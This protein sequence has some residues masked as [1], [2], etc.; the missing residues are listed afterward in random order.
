[1]FGLFKRRKKKKEVKQ[2]SI[3]KHEPV[4]KEE[5]V[6]KEEPDVEEVKEE[7]KTPKKR[8]AAMHIT[9]HKDGG[10][11]VKKEGA[12]RALRL[13]GTQKEAIE[14][15]KQVE[16]EKGTGYIIHKADGS[17]RKKKY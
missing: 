14:F 17:T 8:R 10:W 3:V 4:T 2:D 5:S 12:K 6:T 1:M 15:A 13:F 9:K 11:Q 16:K 7:E